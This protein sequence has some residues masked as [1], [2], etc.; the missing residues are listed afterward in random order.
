MV[1]AWGFVQRVP[2]AVTAESEEIVSQQIAD[3]PLLACLAVE[4]A[5]QAVHHRMESDP[6]A[7]CEINNGN[8]LLHVARRGLTGLSDRPHFFAFPNSIVT[9]TTRFLVPASLISCMRTRWSRVAR[10]GISPPACTRRRRS[11]ARPKHQ[12]FPRTEQSRFEIKLTHISAMDCE[13]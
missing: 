10:I 3:L 11:R 4:S 7:G 6:V 13:R 8:R 9:V 5:T 2:G 12:H 1:R